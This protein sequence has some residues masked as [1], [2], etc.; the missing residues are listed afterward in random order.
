MSVEKRVE[1]CVRLL[2]SRSLDLLVGLGGTIHN[3]LICEPTLVLAGFRTIGPTAA[4]LDR[5]GK[6]TLIVSPAWD[7]ARAKRTT[8][9]HVLATDDVVASLSSF[10]ADAKIRGERIGYAGSDLVPSA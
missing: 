3:F 6:V 10:L 8:S 7:A 9:A 2:E 5:N 4:V 1:S